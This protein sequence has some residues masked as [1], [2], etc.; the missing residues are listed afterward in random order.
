[1]SDTKITTQ[2]EF[3]YAQPENLTEAEAI[4]WLEA[5]LSGNA[6]AADKV[7]IGTMTVTE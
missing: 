2:I 4:A 3:G 1:M 6:P 7:I 5:V